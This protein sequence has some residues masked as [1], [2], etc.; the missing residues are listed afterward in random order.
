MK[1]IPFLRYVLALAIVL[2]SLPANANSD[3]L[4]VSLLTCAPG[5]EAYSLY[6]HTAIRIH[7]LRTDRDVVYN[8][9]MFDSKKPHFVWNFIM[10]RTDYE[11]GTTPFEPFIASYVMRGRYVDEQVL[12]LTTDEAR[13]LSEAL[14]ENARPERRGYR[15]N[16]MNDNC[17]TRAIERIEQCV[18][19]TVFY[20]TE[21]QPEVSFRD[22]IHRLTEEHPWSAFGNDL[23][24]GA[25][26]DTLL[27]RIGE[28]FSPAHAEEYVAGAMVLRS[29][30]SERPLVKETFRYPEMQPTV[31]ES[32]VITPFMAALLLL[33]LAGGCTWHEARRKKIGKAGNVLDITLTLLQGGAGCIIALLFCCSEHPA[34]GSNWLVMW[35]NPLPLLWLPLQIWRTRHGKR[36]I[37]SPLLLGVLL[38]FCLTGCMGVQ[39]FPAAIWILALVLLIR[40]CARKFINI[41]QRNK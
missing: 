7:D 37:Y 35:L 30:G 40:A 12:D 24:L 14:S 16:F 21:H 6:G 33:V 39:E 19:G 28:M 4:Q 23:L 17:T 32:T 34:V 25:E 3:S 13:Q 2:I 11:L 26:T 18:N 20:T 9:G 38:L 36:D 5:N 29:D 8:Y 15:Y 10:G 27:D 1:R 41:G 31:A 22:I